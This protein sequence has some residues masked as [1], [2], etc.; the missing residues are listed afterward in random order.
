MC[1]LVSVDGSGHLD[2]RCKVV[3]VPAN[4]THLDESARYP[5]LDL[6]NSGMAMV[7]CEAFRVRD[8]N[9]KGID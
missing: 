6:F 8:M 7:N 2:S 9:P 4:S 3:D 5:I 1:C